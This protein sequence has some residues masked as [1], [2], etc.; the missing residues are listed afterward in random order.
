MYSLIPGGVWQFCYDFGLTVP[1]RAVQG[2]GHGIYVSYSD[3][4]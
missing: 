2:L 4:L 3:T 1:V